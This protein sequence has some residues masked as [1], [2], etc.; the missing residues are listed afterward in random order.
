[1]DGNGKVHE[2]SLEVILYVLIVGNL[3]FF[4][5]SALSLFMTIALAVFLG[6]HIY[7]VSSNLTTTESN[8]LDEMEEYT[9]LTPTPGQNYY[10][11]GLV[12]NWKEV[13][14]APS[15]I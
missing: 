9:T 14:L 5:V 6:H 3:P 15:S 4:F 10:D 11:K 2:G 8:K 13:F 7:L 12:N 1:V